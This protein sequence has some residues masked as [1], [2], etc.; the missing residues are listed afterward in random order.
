MSLASEVT[1][2]YSLGHTIGL[3]TKICIVDHVV[4]Q[5]FQQVTLYYQTTPYTQRCM[6]TSY[7]GLQALMLA[8]DSL[9][10]LVVYLRHVSFVLGVDHK[11]RLSMSRSDPHVK[12]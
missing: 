11:S 2:W 3:C 7:Y 10:K 12:C 4:G 9:C 5:Y 8:H 6:T 1:H